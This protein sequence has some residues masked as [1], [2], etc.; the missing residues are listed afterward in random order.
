MTGGG[1][2]ASAAQGQVGVSY[3][4]AGWEILDKGGNHQLPGTQDPV[5][6]PDKAESG[7]GAS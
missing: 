2:V 4:A 7:S 5:N 3:T 6:I 1:Q